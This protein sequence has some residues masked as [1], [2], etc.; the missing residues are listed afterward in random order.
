[1]SRTRLHQGPVPKY[2]ESPEGKAFLK[3]HVHKTVPKVH[4]GVEEKLGGSI[5]L[6]QQQQTEVVNLQ[7]RL[8]NVGPPDMRSHS[9]RSSVALR[10][11]PSGT[12]SNPPSPPLRPSRTI[13][14]DRFDTGGDQRSAER[15][16]SMTPKPPSLQTTT[17]VLVKPTRHNARTHTL[18][19]KPR[20]RPVP[21]PK[22]IQG[23]RPGAIPNTKFR[24]VEAGSMRKL[25]TASVATGAKAA[26]G[27]VFSTFEVHPPSCRFG[28]VKEG[29]IYRITL[30]LTNAGNDSTRFRIKC[31]PNFTVKY[32]PGLVAPGIP[33]KLHVEFRASSDGGE[34]RE[35]VEEIRI[36][37]QAEILH[38]PINAVVVR[39]D[40]YDTEAKPLRKNVHLVV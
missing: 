34:R 33:V 5:P 24:D 30:T 36:Y 22:S 26:E 40:L 32:K 4:K 9:A 1:M 31:G 19:G 29:G 8:E 15:S 11:Q 13:T 37:T 38:V 35:V 7:P 2:F 23:A 39:N 21:L 18:S 14:P 16:P 10:R 27:W 6:D 20:G 3:D 12:I 25:A 28:E 17:S